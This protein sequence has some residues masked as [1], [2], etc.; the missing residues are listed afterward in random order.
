MDTTIG[1]FQIILSIGFLIFLAYL[2]GLFTDWLAKK[3]NSN[4]SYRGTTISRP[5]YHDENMKSISDTKDKILS[6]SKDII[7]KTKSSTDKKMTTA[8][9]IKALKDLEEL[10]NQNVITIEEYQSLK[11][12]LL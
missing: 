4:V 11:S 3:T 5:H 2:W 6:K 1:I 9:K 10:K 12:K 7:E 8:D